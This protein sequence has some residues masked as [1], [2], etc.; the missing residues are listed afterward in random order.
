MPLSTI[1]AASSGAVFSRAT[2]TVSM[3][4]PTGSA[5]L[6]A[7]SRWLIVIALGTPFIRSRPLMS[8][9]CPLPSSGGQ[10]VP[11]PC[12]MRS[13]LDSPSSRLWLRRTYAMMASSILS[14]PTRT[15][16]E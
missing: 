7:I 3:I 8:N 14:P 5:R 4:A 6:S 1:S 9:D 11:M 10:A 12:L 15:E 2:L 16:R 13:A